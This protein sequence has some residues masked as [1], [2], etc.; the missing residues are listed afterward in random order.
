MAA[1][2]AGGPDIKAG[3]P[4]TDTEATDPSPP[5]ATRGGAMTEASQGAQTSYTLS[6]PGRLLEVLELCLAD[7][8]RAD[9][10]GWSAPASL[11]RDLERHFGVH[12]PVTT[13]ERA[14]RVLAKRK[15]VRLMVDDTGTL[16]YRL[17]DDE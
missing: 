17:R 13:I 1:S 3:R 16:W 10:S 6:Q 8:L 2:S 15:R 9:R 14:L 12:A 5:F 4:A 11:G 7:R